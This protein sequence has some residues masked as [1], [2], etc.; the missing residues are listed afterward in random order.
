[1]DHNSDRSVRIRYSQ[2]FVSVV[3]MLINHSVYLVYKS[4]L[5]QL[6]NSFVLLTNLYRPGCET[7]IH[8]NYQDFFGIGHR[9]QLILKSSSVKLDR[10]KEST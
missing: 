3:C 8:L 2:G 6:P 7:D 5:I 10:Q 9:H 1:M 4:S